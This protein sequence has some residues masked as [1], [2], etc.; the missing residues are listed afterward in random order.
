LVTTINQNEEIDMRD[1]R[2][3]LILFS[4]RGSEVR[5]YDISWKNVLFYSSML[6]VIL[7][8]LIGSI[9]F[10]LSNFF[11]S[12]RITSLQKANETLTS[13]LGEMK[14]SISQVATQ[15]SKIETLDDD[16]RMIVG[17]DELDKDIRNAGQGGSAYPLDIEVNLLPRETREEVAEMNIQIDQLEKKIQLALESQQEINRKFDENQDILDHLPTIKP[18]ETGRITCKF[19]WRSDPFTEKPALHTGIDIGAPE[20]TPVY[21]AAYGVVFE[22]NYNYSPNRNYGRFVIIDHGYGRQTRYAHLE[23]IN[24]KPGQKVKRWQQIG[25]V[26]ETGRATGPHLHYEVI[27]NNAHVDPIKYFFE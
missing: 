4:M 5:D 18:V 7:I 16:L 25:T 13:Q 15:M 8:I 1:K 19:G 21:A 14:I 11:Q 9:V 3:K 12:T 22:I 2:I 17:L 24:V 26:G 6:S 20:G 27:E 23:N 10:V